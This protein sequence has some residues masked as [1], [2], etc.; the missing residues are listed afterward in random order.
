MKNKMIESALRGSIVPENCEI[1]LLDAELDEISG[2][3]CGQ[4]SCGIYKIV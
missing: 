1:E 4:F 2:G 3:A